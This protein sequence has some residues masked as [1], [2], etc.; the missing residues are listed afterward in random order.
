MKPYWALLFSD[1]LLFAK[2]SR[3]RVL[4]ITEDPVPLIHI[5][6]SMFNVR[7]KCKVQRVLVIGRIS[8]HCVIP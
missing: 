7:K 6:E 1:I 3:D 8:N 4:F 5:T 2:V